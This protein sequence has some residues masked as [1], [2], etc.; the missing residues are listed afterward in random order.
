M[1]DRL[2]GLVVRVSGYRSRG[3]GFDS[4]RYQIF[5]EVVGLERGPL[6][7]MR[8]IEELLEWTSSGFGPETEINGHGD[9]LRWQHDTLYPLKLALTSPT[10]GGRSVGTVGWRTKAPDLFMDNYAHVSNA[11]CSAFLGNGSVNTFPRQ[12]IEVLLETVF[13]NRSVQR[14]YKEGDWKRKLLEIGHNLL[15]WA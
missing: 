15:Y 6:S 10:S 14:D 1:C 3:P 5:W 7:L 4:R 8:I 12:K 2:C 9:S 13:A 11:G